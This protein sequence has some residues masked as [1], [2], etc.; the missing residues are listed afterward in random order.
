MHSSEQDGPSEW[1]A[2][3]LETTEHLKLKSLAKRGF[4]SLRTDEWKISNIGSLKY[5]DDMVSS[6]V[7]FPHEV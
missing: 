5:L 3:T 1:D 6:K 2:H 4:V 7:Y